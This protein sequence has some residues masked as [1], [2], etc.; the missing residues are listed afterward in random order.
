MVFVFRG[1][2]I[3]KF[4][5]NV[6]FFLKKYIIIIIIIVV[7]YENQ[8]SGLFASDSIP[9]KIVMS[10]KNKYSLINIEVVELSRF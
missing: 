3:H 6:F 1:N 9:H 8:E 5:V 10:Y 4:F 7:M 2:V